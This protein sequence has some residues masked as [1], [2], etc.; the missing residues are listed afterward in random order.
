MESVEDEEPVWD[1]IFHRLSCDPISNIFSFLTFGDLSSNSI[2]STEWYQHIIPNHGL[3]ISLCQS[4][5][6]DK[7][8]PLQYRQLVGQTKLSQHD[9]MV[10]PTNK[11]PLECSAR[12]AFRLAYMDRKRTTL[13]VDELVAFKWY[14]RFKKEAGETWMNIDP[15]WNFN[16]AQDPDTDEKE[17]DHTDDIMHYKPSDLVGILTEDEI[18]EYKLKQLKYEKAVY[19]SRQSQTPL[20]EHEKRLSQCMRI[21]FSR[22]GTMEWQHNKRMADI[23]NTQE[24]E[25]RFGGSFYKEKLFGDSV[26][27]NS[28]PKKYVSRHPTNWGFVMQSWW[29]IY[30][31]FPMPM[32]GSKDDKLMQH[33][34]CNTSIDDDEEMIQFN[35]VDETTTQQPNKRIGWMNDCGVFDLEYLKQMKQLICQ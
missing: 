7:Y 29:V 33:N 22:D 20:S 13:T 14:F 3:W 18:E 10:K 4:F 35:Y 15:F 9:R 12:K 34:A 8:V 19:E 21:V 27:V 1:Y 31:S 26:Q 25:W 11:L 23:V 16:D 5:W 6:C 24:F 30:T 17:W 32:I 28:Y 2:V